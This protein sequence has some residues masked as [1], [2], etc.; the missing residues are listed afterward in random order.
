MQKG[1]VMHW[2]WD[3]MWARIGWELGE[4]IWAIIVLGA[5]IGAFLIYTVIRRNAWRQWRRSRRSRQLHRWS[6]DW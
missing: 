1:S 3:V 5:L 2:M 4:L 6:N